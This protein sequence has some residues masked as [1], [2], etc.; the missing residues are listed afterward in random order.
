MVDV[1][2]QAGAK[3]GRFTLPV[4]QQADRGHDQGW[5]RQAPGFFFNE[6]VRQGLQG[7][8]QT[9]VIGQDAG[10]L[11][12][13]QKLQPVQALLLIRPQSRLQAGGCRHLGQSVDAAHLLHQLGQVL[14]TRPAHP[15][16]QGGGRAQSFQA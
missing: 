15:L 10:Q 3:A 8:A 14:G 7:F 12:R 13:A 9:H 5:L 4:A 6:D 1:G 11:V 16:P 2:A